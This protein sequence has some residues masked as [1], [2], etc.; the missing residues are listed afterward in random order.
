MK[1][2]V[3]R[4]DLRGGREQTV[5][6]A[7]IIKPIGPG[8]PEPGLGVPLGV[9]PAHLPAVDAQRGEEG[10]AVVPAHLVGD[11]DIELV[12]DALD[13]DGVA[14]VGSLRLQ[15]GQGDP[16]A[17]HDGLSRAEDHVGADRADVEFGA[18]HVRGPVGVDHVLP[19]EQLDDRDA[20][21]LGQRLD[22][23][24]VGVPAAGLPP[25]NGLVADVHP[26]RQLQ[27]CDLSLLAQ[28]PDHGAGDI[29]IH[30]GHLPGPYDNTPAPKGQPTIRRHGGDKCRLC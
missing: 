9:K 11:R 16:A 17:A 26:F 7:V 12:L 21:G 8:D 10:D 3:L 2:I 20:Q 19:G 22:Q 14:F 5:P 27:L 29:L 18:Q 15:R 4:R 6:V 1:N 13:A 23:G 25:G 24:D 30:S 28:A